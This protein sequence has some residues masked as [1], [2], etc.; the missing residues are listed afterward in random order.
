[1]KKFFKDRSYRLLTI[2]IAMMLVSMIFA[3]LLM[4]DFG[5]VSVTKI[6][7][8]TDAGLTLSALLY[9]PDSATAENPAPGV[10]V[11]HGWWKTKESQSSTAMEL[12][13]RGMVVI[14]VD[15]YG[16][17]DSTEGRD[18]FV[19][20]YNALQML[21]KLPYVDSQ[22]LG[23]TGHSMGGKCCTQ[24]VTWYNAGGSADIKAM[25][26][27]GTDVTYQDSDEKWINYYGNRDVCIIAAR[28]DDFEYHGSTIHGPWYNAPR[29]FWKTDRAKS[30]VNFG[31][32][33]KNITEEVEVGRVYTREIDGRTARRALYTPTQIHSWFVLSPIS[34]GLTCTF[35]QES[36]EAPNPL[37]SSNQLGFLKELFTALGL[38]GMFTFAV[39]LVYVLVDHTKFFAVLKSNAPGKPLEHPDREGKFWFWGSIL[40][41]GIVSAVTLFPI[42]TWINTGKTDPLLPIVQAKAL[43]IWGAVSGIVSLLMMYLSFR[44]YGKKTGFDLKERGIIIEKAAVGKTILAGVMVAL[45]SYFWVFVADYFFTVDF[46]FW[47]FAARSFDSGK[48][49]YIL[50][51]IP[52]YLMYYIPNSMATNC[53]RYNKLGKH[54]WV[55]TAVVS[56]TNALGTIALL[57]IQYGT[58]LITGYSKWH[59]N[60]S[61]KSAVGWTYAIVGILIVAP[62]V[63]RK[64][65]KKTNNPYLAGIINGILVAIISCT[66]TSTILFTMPSYIP[67]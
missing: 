20:S 63:A 50:V 30:F 13:R 67:G 14:A 33:P 51:A 46:R 61:V 11:V 26:I 47:T 65:Y 38:A 19:D 23:M 18:N 3:N 45:L 24:A 1:M 52:Y 43:G 36:L 64:I 56:I 31:D 37:S 48:W 40:V 66:S 57:V 54:E 32:D 7:T 8:E 10:V 39:A 60:G 42:A 12:A 35:L 27:A 34:T 28:Y 15:M 21:S 59:P 41:A 22:R 16:H 9:K 4:T 17:G 58:F 29:D 5:K 49:K 44:F 53:F 6:K 62:I 55:N 2:A 25:V